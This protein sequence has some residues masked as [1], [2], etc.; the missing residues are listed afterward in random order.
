MGGVRSLLYNN[1][2]AS[3][4]DTRVCRYPIAQATWIPEGSLSGA[5]K[6]FD[7][8]MTDATAE[9]I[10]LNPKG[11]VLLEEARHGGWDI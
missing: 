2:M 10:D 1:L 6:V 4:L 11:P 3:R 9:G 7:R 8:F 5:S